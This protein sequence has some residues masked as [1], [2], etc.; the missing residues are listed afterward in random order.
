MGEGSK[1]KDKEMNT[2]TISIEA[3][4][5]SPQEHFVEQVADES[6]PAA[7]VLTDQQE[8]READSHA[9]LFVP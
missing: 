3:T 1:G 6:L 7:Q 8:N 4:E 2:Q 9:S 5:I